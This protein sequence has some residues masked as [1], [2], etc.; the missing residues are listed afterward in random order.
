MPLVQTKPTS[1]GR[2]FVV[3]VS[4]PELHKGAPFEPLVE[5]K[6]KSGGRNAEIIFNFFGADVVC[7][8][9]EMTIDGIEIDMGYLNADLIELPEL[10]L[11][12]YESG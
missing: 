2:R 1:P 11:S 4:T 12:K 5:K 8:N 3:R 6:T 9:G 7:K 10:K